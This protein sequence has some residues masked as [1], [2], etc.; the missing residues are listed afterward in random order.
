M[1]EDVTSHPIRV[2]PPSIWDQLI[3]RE[4][5]FKTENLAKVSI[6]IPISNAAQ[7][8]SITLESILSQN[9][10]NYEIIVVDCSTDRSI[11]IIKNFNS[12]KIRIFSVSQNKRYAMLN[13]GLSQAT[14]SYV[15]FLFP[16]D[17]YIY[18][19][20]LKYIMT[21]ASEQDLPHLIYCGTLIREGNREAKILFRELNLDL[22]KRGQ[23][24]TS[25]QSCWFKTET[26]KAL[27]KFNDNYRMRGGF[28]LLCRFYLKGNLRFMPVARVLTDYDL[29]SVSKEMIFTH[30]WETFITINYYF[31]FLQALK[32]LF[33][34]KDSKRLLKLWL[35]N[36]KTAFS[37]RK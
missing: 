34:Q 29:R 33:I 22:L 20:T 16:G 10:S 36:L 19:E 35:H 18:H 15:N 27:G 26:I 31:G 32:W 17:F 30:F 6:I 24:P 2:S 11:E 5:T 1:T 21:L 9:Y 37:G 12:D 7:S 3:H 28:E 4:E 14:G 8:I 23:Q 25:L 13:K